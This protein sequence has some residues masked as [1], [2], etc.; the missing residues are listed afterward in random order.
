MV[1][2]TLGSPTSIFWKRR[3]S[4]RSRS[5]EAL[6][7]WYVVEP[8]QRSRPL[9]SAGLS[10]LDASM[11]PPLVA[12]AP[13]MVWISSMKRMASGCSCSALST[14][15]RR[16]SNWPR[17]L[18]PASSAPMSSEKM[19]AFFSTSGTLPSWMCSARPSAMAVLPTPVSPT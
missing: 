12:P 1:S 15:L 19:T 5:K 14:P 16:S 9:A 6:N 7:S 13:T 18:V 8:M 4:A 10:R 17:N 3:D 11:E 2:S